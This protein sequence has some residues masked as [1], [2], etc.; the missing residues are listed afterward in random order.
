MFI[1]FTFNLLQIVILKIKIFKKYLSIYLF[2]FISWAF[3]FCLH[4][5][6][7]GA[8]GSYKSGVASCHVH[9]EN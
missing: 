3:G 8:V 5:Y 2:I 4:V 7:C 9:V 6:L 1:N